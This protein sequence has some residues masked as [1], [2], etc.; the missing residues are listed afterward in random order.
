MRSEL[1][2]SHVFVGLALAT[3]FLD[4]NLATGGSQIFQ[5]LPSISSACT[6]NGQQSCHNTS[7]VEDLCCFESPGVRTVMK[8]WTPLTELYSNFQGL[9]LQT[10]VNI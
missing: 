7:V 9:L 4:I 5:Q 8:S 1:L 6:R 10:Q 3:P 2:L